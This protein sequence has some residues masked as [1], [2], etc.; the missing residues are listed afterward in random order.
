MKDG[1]VNSNAVST[2]EAHDARDL[3]VSK[4]LSVWGCRNDLGTYSPT[5]QI[6]LYLFCKHWTMSD[7][8]I[9]YF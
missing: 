1:T 4:D 9:L 3:S 7:F 6:S 5:P 2:T 8:V